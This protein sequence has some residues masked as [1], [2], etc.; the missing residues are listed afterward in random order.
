MGMIKM[1]D[2]EF[3][4]YD[5]NSDIMPADDKPMEAMPVEE[6]NMPVNKLSK[7]NM[8]KAPGT[9][10][11]SPY[12]MAVTD[13]DQAKEGGANSFLYS[14]AKEPEWAGYHTPNHGTIILKCICKEQSQPHHQW[15][16]IGALLQ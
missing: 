15:I 8:A 13:G 6:D 12:N 4:D 14:M 3:K 7:Y 5:G 16:S 9:G 1:P 11:E 2:E 10:N